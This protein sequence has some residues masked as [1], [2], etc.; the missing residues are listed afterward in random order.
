M[1][2]LADCNL[3][4]HV[5]PALRRNRSVSRRRECQAVCLSIPCRI[6]DEGV[7]P[8]ML[9]VYSTLYGALQAVQLVHTILLLLCKSPLAHQMRLHWM[10]VERSYCGCPWTTQRAE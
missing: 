2:A 3:S 7:H 1:Q 10:G 8:A 6:S 9:G 5:H 4:D